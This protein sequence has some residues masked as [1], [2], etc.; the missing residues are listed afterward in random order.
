[1][2]DLLREQV[3]TIARMGCQASSKYGSTW[4]YGNGIHDYKMFSN[5]KKGD[6]DLQTN[7][8]WPVVES[9]EN[10]QMN[11]KF[12]DPCYNNT[13]VDC[14][15]GIDDNTELLATPGI[16]CCRFTGYLN[17]GI[18]LLISYGSSTL[19]GICGF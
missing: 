4:F 16:E 14:S 12:L 10:A 6:E 8:R 1:M 9:L 7:Y 18:D 3:Q 11:G 13:G 5:Y 19:H 2:I 15:T 17:K